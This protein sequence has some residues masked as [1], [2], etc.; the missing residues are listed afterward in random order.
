[1]KTLSI[2]LNFLIYSVAFS[3]PQLQIEGNDVYDWGKIDPKGQPLTAK[4]KIFNKGNDTLKIIGVQP[5]CSCTTAPLDKNTIEPKGYA[6]LS[7]TLHVNNDGHIQ[8]P[9]RISSNDPNTPFKYLMLKADIV[10]PIGLS[11]R[12]INFGNLEI[13]KEAVSKISILN[14]T[15]ST[16]IIKDIIFEPKEL[17]V[18]IKNNTEI[19]ANKEYILEVK[20]T[21]RNI[22]N[23]S[24]KITLITDYK[25][26]E[27]AE[28][29]V[30]GTF[31]PANKK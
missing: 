7:I 19:G 18:N 8:K 1:M 31:P 30:W 3:Q 27:T 9:I 25:E 28:I 11:Q 4:V 5:G 29:T 17:E 15:N 10:R 16:I 20:F 6:T 23:I 14:N 12:F 2:I 13:N 26:M 22:I 24:G 21:P